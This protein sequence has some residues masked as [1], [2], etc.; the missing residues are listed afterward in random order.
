MDFIFNW[1][2][3]NPLI[4]VIV[5]LILFLIFTYNNLNAKKKRV[6]KSFSTIDVY[7]EK[8]YDEIGA[9]LEQLLKGYQFEENTQTTIASARTGILNAKTG[10]VNDKVNAINGL[11]TLLASPTIRTEAYPEL[12]AIE[13]LAVFTM[14][15]TSQV[16]DDLAAARI[17]Y[18]SN[19]TSYNTKISSFP[20][21]LVAGIFGF[22][23]PFELFKVSESKKE[24]PTFSSIKDNL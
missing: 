6:E 15:K 22:K 4:V 7:L 18:N 23:V 17:Q 16:E 13:K 3:E 8:R 5:L 20:T 9:L 1:M 2:G 12:Q 10:S 11:T 14:Q 19:A 21:A 24:R